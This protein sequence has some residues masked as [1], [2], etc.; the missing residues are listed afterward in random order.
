MTGKPRILCVLIELRANLYLT[1][2][3]AAQVR[4]IFTLPSQLGH[5]AYPLAYIEWFTPFGQIDLSTGMHIIRRSTQ[6]GRRNA[7]VV[8]ML[9]I[10]G[11]CHLIPKASVVDAS[12]TSDNVV[13]LI[14]NF[15]FNHYISTRMFSLV[16]AT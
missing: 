10:F 2:L 13:E 14:S 9:N 11:T 8:P 12:W 3:R 6:N 16:S 7:A 5:L 15:Y 4:V 1:G